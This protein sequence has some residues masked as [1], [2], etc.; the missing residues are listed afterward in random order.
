M[1]ESRNCVDE[2]QKTKSHGKKW[3]VILRIYDTKDKNEITKP[4]LWGKCSVDLQGGG[5]SYFEANLI[6]R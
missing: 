5:E 1:F 6:M 2:I 4:Q 3:M